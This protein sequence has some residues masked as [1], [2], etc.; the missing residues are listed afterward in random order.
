M[1]KRDVR[2]DAYIAKA[3]PFAKPIL[4]HIR[5]AVHAACPEIEETIKWGM[6][7][8]DHKGPVCHMAAFKAHCALGFW[9]GSLVLGTGEWREGAMGQMGR[10]TSISDLPP[11]R[12]LTRL[13]KAAAA[14]NEAGVAVKRKAPVKKPLSI[15]DDLAAA[16]KLKKNAKARATFEALAPGHKREYADWITEAKRDETRARRI[17]QALEWLAEGK[18]RNWKYGRS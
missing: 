3:A 1:S 10:V 4:E 8:F 16:L 2:V 13:I 6:P 14:L 7:F 17:A 12:E 11:K 5:E 18:S 15:P 9:K